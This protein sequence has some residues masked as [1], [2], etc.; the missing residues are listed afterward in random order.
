MTGFESPKGLALANGRLYV[1]D[2]PE[3]VEMD[4]P[5]GRIVT[6]HA[7]PDGPGGF[8]DCTAGPIRRRHTGSRC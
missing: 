6:R 2:D 3:L 4:L 1:G 7:P 5:S 8:N